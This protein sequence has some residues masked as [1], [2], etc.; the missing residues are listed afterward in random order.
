MSNIPNETDL[1]G[2]T[3]FERLMDVDD[4]LP[5]WYDDVFD[6]DGNLVKPMSV[7][8]DLFLS[9]SGPTTSATIVELPDI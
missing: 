1:T 9:P 5:K 7:L 6:E 2:E 3:D 8:D 4:R